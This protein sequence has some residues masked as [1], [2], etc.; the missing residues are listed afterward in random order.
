MSRSPE[1]E[2]QL[3]GQNEISFLKRGPVGRSSNTVYRAKQMDWSGEALAGWWGGNWWE[4]LRPAP[5]LR[6]FPVDYR[7]MLTSPQN[8]FANK[9]V[10]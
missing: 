6:S 3:N 2:Q 9:A 1:K 5:F 10:E 7:R 4:V 8:I